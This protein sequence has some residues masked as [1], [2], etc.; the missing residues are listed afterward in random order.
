MFELSKCDRI[1]I[2]TRMVAAL[3]NVD[4]HLAGSVAG[5]LGLAELP[6]A[7]PAAREPVRDLAAPRR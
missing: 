3:R 7:L 4:E 5:G 2:R 6:D 1:A